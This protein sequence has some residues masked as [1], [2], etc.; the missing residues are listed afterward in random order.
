MCAAEHVKHARTRGEAL[1]LLERAAEHL[2]NHLGAVRAV[3]QEL[4]QAARVNRRSRDGAEIELEGAR[5]SS[6]R[7]NHI[8][9]RREDP[10]G[11]IEGSEAVGGERA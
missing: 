8:S 9:R 4:E 6:L 10:V 5:A 11:R 3:E 1:L 2:E 7:V